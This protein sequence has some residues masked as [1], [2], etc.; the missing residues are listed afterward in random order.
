M[1]NIHNG[2][3][4]ASS[5]RRSGVPGEHVAFRES[6][7]TGE[8]TTMAHDVRARVLAATHQEELLRISNDLF[9][10]QQ[11]LDRVA[12]EEVVL[13]F[14]HD[15]FC[16]VHFLY[17]L[18]RLE[19]P[20][21]EYIW[22]PTPLGQC[23]VDEL[24]QAFAA[25]RPVSRS[26]IATAQ[27]VWRDYTSDDPTSLNNWLDAADSLPFLREG[28]TLHASRF[29]STRNGLGAIEN[30]LLAM[31]EPVSRDFPS[32]FDQFTA[33]APRFGFGDSEVLRHVRALANRETPLLT[34][35]DQTA[36]ARL[37]ITP[38][39]EQVLRGEA[40]DLTLNE[41]DYWLGGAHLTK[42]KQWRWDGTQ[43]IASR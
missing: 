40:D 41:P 7:I 18:Q 15:L 13:W 9:E 10:Q 38:A 12:E 31:I 22:H 33:E 32:L 23:D 1:I 19:A 36:K 35:S 26:L 29:P 42:E 21:L 8:V 20:R 30:R 3:V 39:G 43:I 28:L 25:R 4:V 6:L 24:H 5:A 11:L 2:D 16:L 14:E 37:A 17:L 34:M 27:Q